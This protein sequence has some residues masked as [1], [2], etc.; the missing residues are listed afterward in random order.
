MD[1]LPKLTVHEGVIYAT[2]FCGSGVV[3]ARW[4]GQKAALRILEGDH[5]S[6]AFAARPF[7]AIP[8]YNGKPWFLP[9]MT[10]WYQFLDRRN[11]IKR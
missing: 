10:H 2:G 4:L 6:S 5:V 11:G 1:Q 3:W 8:L 9:I 7:R